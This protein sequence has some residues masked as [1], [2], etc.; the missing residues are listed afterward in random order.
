MMIPMTRPSSTTGRHPIFR[1]RMTRAASS[2]ASS[3][4][5]VSGS[6]HMIAETELSA[7]NG[8]GAS[9]EVASLRSRSVT[10][11]ARRSPSRTARCRNPFSLI[12]R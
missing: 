10:T 8:T 7:G 9:A 2:T 1:S 11:P 6:L 12:V 5:A 3:A 4:F